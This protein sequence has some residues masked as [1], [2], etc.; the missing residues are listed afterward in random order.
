MPVITFGQENKAVPRGVTT[1]GEPKE[2]TFGQ[3][4]VTFEPKTSIDSESRVKDVRPQESYL[5]DAFFNT[6]GL[7]HPLL[8][9]ERSCK[10]HSRALQPW[11]SR[12]HSRSPGNKKSCGD[13]TNGLLQDSASGPQ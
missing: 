1:F 3:N 10:F 2:V 12:T 9:P 6:A 11:K 5:L 7:G 13:C 4:V 8:R